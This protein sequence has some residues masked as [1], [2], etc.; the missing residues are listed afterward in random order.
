MGNSPVDV[1]EAIAMRAHEGAVTKT[2][3]PYIHHSRRVVANVVKI[4]DWSRFSV[5][6]REA[7]ECAAWLHDVVEDNPDFSLNALRAEG[8]PELAVEVVALLSKNLGADGNAVAEH[9]PEAEYLSRIRANPLALRVKLADLADNS[10]VIRR[11]EW[12]A[13]Q[14]AGLVE[15]SKDPGRYSR[16]RR[17][18]DAEE[19]FAEWFSERVQVDPAA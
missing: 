12:L 1:A 6:D 8:I 10:N 19:K 17:E 16:Y 15:P 13:M 18:L 4:P 3:E 11:A 14:D 9:V 5:A 7:L 2:G